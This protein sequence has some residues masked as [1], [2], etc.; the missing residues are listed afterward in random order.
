MPGQ[1]KRTGIKFLDVHGG[2]GH[3][4]KKFVKF[5][6]GEAQIVNIRADG[7]DLDTHEGPRSRIAIYGEWRNYGDGFEFVENSPRGYW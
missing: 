6:E 4:R 3:P 2:P 5:D 7:L 1:E